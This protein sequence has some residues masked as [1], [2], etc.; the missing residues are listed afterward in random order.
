[1][2]F[3]QSF[4]ADEISWLIELCDSDY[5]WNDEGH[6]DNS[7]ILCIPNRFSHIAEDDIADL[8][9]KEFAKKTDKYVCAGYEFSDEDTLRRI[10]D[11]DN[12]YMFELNVIKVK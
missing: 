8:I 1:M 5:E 7:I 12:V 9:S 3:I 6:C 10:G 2:T 11:D 4:I